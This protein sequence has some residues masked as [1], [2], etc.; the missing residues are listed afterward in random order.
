M[1]VKNRVE[2]FKRNS[3]DLAQQL[4]QAAVTDGFATNVEIFKGNSADLAQQLSQTAV[5]D[6]FAKECLEIPEKI[7]EFWMEIRWCL[8][9]FGGKL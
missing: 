3:A 8:V 4:S 7:L 2:K 9:F 6:G 5:T 1:P